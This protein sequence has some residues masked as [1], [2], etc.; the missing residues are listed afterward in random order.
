MTT[1]DKRSLIEPS[2]QICVGTDGY[3][4]PWLCADVT[5]GNEIWYTIRLFPLYHHEKRLTT[6][7]FVQYSSSPLEYQATV[8]LNTTKPLPVYAGIEFPTFNAIVQKQVEWCVEQCAELGGQWS[9]HIE[10]F[11]VTD[12]AINYTFNNPTVAVA[13]KLIWL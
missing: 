7:R 12:L 10:S 8:R 1:N 6:G 13:F 4:E 9:I 5:R 3:R 11:S 2:A